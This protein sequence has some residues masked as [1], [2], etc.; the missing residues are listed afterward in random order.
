MIDWGLAGKK[1][2]KYGMKKRPINNLQLSINSRAEDVF[3]LAQLIIELFNKGN[4][5]ANFADYHVYEEIQGGGDPE[6][7]NTKSQNDT[8]KIKEI[9]VR[10]TNLFKEFE[11]LKVKNEIIKNFITKILNTDYLTNLY[12][13][14]KPGSTVEKLPTLTE[15]FEQSKPSTPTPPPLP[16]TPRP[17]QG[18]TPQSL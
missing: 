5:G 7:Q 16:E 4:T 11:I 8:Y 9:E 1:R 13:Q 3:C 6:G 2:E 12:E 14:D 18:P 10:K 15:L 17:N